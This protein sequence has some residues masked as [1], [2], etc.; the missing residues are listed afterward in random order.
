MNV[1]EIVHA[2]AALAFGAA[3]LACGLSAQAQ[4]PRH[5]KGFMSARRRPSSMILS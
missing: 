2:F 3:A 4:V 5:R 1:Q